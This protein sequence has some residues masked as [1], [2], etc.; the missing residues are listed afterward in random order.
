MS[1]HHSKNSQ[2]V[3]I[4][5]LFILASLPI[6]AAGQAGAEPAL[7]LFAKADLGVIEQSLAPQDASTRLTW[8]QLSHE[9]K[10]VLAPLGAEW[11][12]LR[13][14][15][16]EKMLDIVNDYPKMDAQQQ[17]RLQRRLIKW[18]RMTPFERENA[19]KRYQ[20]FQTLSAEQKQTLREKWQQYQ[21]K[22][23][24][25]EGDDIEFSISVP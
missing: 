16:R 3:Y 14:W 24:N 2:P 6:R 1:G 5:V 20:Q 22:S 7:V 23:G 25:Y 11:D 18:S 13:P 8:A 17:L 4:W 9:Q 15:Q 19:R 21:H 12:Q 10:R